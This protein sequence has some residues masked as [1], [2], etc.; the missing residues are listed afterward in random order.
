MFCFFSRIGALDIILLLHIGMLL[1]VDNSALIR[2]QTWGC[3]QVAVGADENVISTMS[4][5]NMCFKMYLDVPLLIG[6]FKMCFGT[7]VLLT[8]I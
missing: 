1:I 4:R 2:I 7:H 3:V 5:V 8:R 6:G